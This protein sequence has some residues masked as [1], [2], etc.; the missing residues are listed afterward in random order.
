MS[1]R[2]DPLEGK[3]EGINAGEI[4]QLTF[5]QEKDEPCP[6]AVGDTFQLRNCF[7]EVTEITRRKRGK[8]KEGE[9]YFVA[10]FTRYRKA[11]R[12][13]LLA[14]RGYTHDPRQA[15]KADL[16][17]HDLQ[18]PEPEA[19]P[20]HEVAELDGSMDAYHRH[21]MVVAEA[22][23]AHEALP[24]EQRLAS[25]KRAA[26]E[27]HIDISSHERLIRRK[28]AEIERKVFDREEAA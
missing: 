12:P 5:K 9:W 27:A 8:G 16:Q 24:I 23:A 15:I 21:L 28:V 25:V 7:I 13:Y 4:K 10:Q 3:R 2:Q 1:A 17:D 6:V 18:E 11:S 19:V 26:K 22:R 14:R 20:P